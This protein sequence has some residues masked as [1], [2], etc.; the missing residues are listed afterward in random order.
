[1]DEVCDAE[2]H[3]VGMEVRLDFAVHADR[4]FRRVEI[5]IGLDPRSHRLERVGVLRAPEGPVGF[6][7]H[8]FADV[9]ADGVAQDT[10]ERVGFAQVLRLAADHHAD[11]ALVL[12]LCRVDRDD[13]GLVVR[14]DGVD[15]AIADLGAR[16]HIDRRPGLLRVFA[17]VR[18]V[19]E[20]GSVEG[21]RDERHLD[22]DVVEA[23]ELRG[24]FEIAEWRTA[25]LADA[26]AVENPVSACGTGGGEMDPAH[27]SDRE[28]P[29]ARRR[30]D[31]GV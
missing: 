22:A 19:I 27:V 13:D 26:I 20:A 31:G 24:L 1:M 14:N 3:V 15:R 29:G 12:D 9:V 16:R 11:L 18:H 23:M 17:N 30:A 4:R 5:D 25:H 21:A 2:Q 7:P 6:L 28:S 8:A 10:R